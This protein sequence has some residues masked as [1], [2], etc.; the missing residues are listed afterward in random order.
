[1]KIFKDTSL[2]YIFFTYYIIFEIVFAYNLSFIGLSGFSRVPYLRLGLM[3]FTV[4]FFLK[5]F[6]NLKLNLRFKR[7]I[8]YQDLFVKLFILSALIS[9]PVGLFNR[10]PIVYFITDF[11]YIL[12]GAFLFF[13]TKRR[14]S[15][16]DINVPLLVHNRILFKKLSYF[17]SLVTFL[18]ILFNLDAPALLPIILIVL[19]FL[20]VIIKNYILACFMLVPYLYLVLSSNRTQLIVFLLVVFFL[21]LRYIRKF[22]SLKTVFLYS[23]I[24]G[25]VFFVFRIELLEGLLFFIDKHSN[26]GYR[27]YQLLFVFKEGIDFSNPFFTSISQRI[28]EAQAVYDYWTTNLY[29]FIF[30]AGSGG[31]IDGREVFNDSSVLNSALLG[32]DK[33]HN[34]HILPMALIYRYGLFGLCLFVILIIMAIKSAKNILDSSDLQKVFWNLFFLSWFV[35]SMPAAS[36]L[37]TMPLFWIS[38]AMINNKNY[39]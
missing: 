39:I 34:I 3:L 27:I 8:K 21:F 38:L 5:D 30:G 25:I 9:L 4:V 32:A 15:L 20:N 17:F 33:I 36:F 12:L 35:F 28:L 16:N 6:L 13:I 24:F 23:F 22:F 14:N 2:E 26:V 29:T 19:V 11:V 31:V 10:N 18:C 37:W 7:S 1:M